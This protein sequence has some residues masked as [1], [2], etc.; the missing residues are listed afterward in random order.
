[1]TKLCQM[2]MAAADW[3]VNQNISLRVLMDLK[4]AGMWEAAQQVCSNESISGLHALIAA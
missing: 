4:D 3:V 2:T 1:M